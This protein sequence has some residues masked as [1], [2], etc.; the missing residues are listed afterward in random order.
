MIE[1][2]RPGCPRAVPREHRLHPKGRGF[3][4]RVEIITNKAWPAEPRNTDNPVYDLEQVGVMVHHHVDGKIHSQFA[5]FT[6]ASGEYWGLP[7][8]D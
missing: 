4:R 7:L 2:D 6:R 8:E 1:A 5:H 3:S